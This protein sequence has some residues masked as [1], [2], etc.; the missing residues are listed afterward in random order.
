MLPRH[1]QAQQSND[2]LQGENALNFQPI[3]KNLDDRA[4][5][6]RAAAWRWKPFEPHQIFVCWENPSEAYKPQMAEVQSAIRST[7]QA[8]S[9][10]SFVWSSNACTER[11]VGI[12]IE[13]ADA[14]AVTQGLGRQV[15]GVHNGMT[16]NFDFRNWNTGCRDASVYDTCV[17]AVAVHEFGHAIGFAHEQNRPDTPGECAQPAQGPNGDAMLT[18]WDVHSVMNYCNPT[19]INGGVLS[20]LDIQALQTVYGKPQT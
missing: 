5:M 1:G 14:G 2:P 18:P 8:Y 3:A 9:S 12:R 10:I 19:Y 4:Y 16:L 7:W 11:S 17:K 15:D 20:Q 6:L 13:I